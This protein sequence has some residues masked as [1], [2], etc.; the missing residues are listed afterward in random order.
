MVA[1]LAT[2]SVLAGIAGGALHSAYPSRVY[3]PGDLSAF[4]MAY[5]AMHVLV[6]GAAFYVRETLWWCGPLIICSQSITSIGMKG[7]DS[8]G[9]TLTLNLSLIPPL[10]L[11]SVLGAQQA[12]RISARRRAIGLALIVVLLF[13]E[14]FVWYFVQVDRCLDRG[15]RW[16]YEFDLV[17][18]YQ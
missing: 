3:E 12:D 2:L 18:E 16:G 8:A 6:F 17:C 5:G 4:V 7:V 11:V 15:G 10:V 14:A 1:A 13:L 9:V